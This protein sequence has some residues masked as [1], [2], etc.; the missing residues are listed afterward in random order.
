MGDIRQQLRDL[1]KELNTELEEW[2]KIPKPKANVVLKMK[3]R[4]R[5]VLAIQKILLDNP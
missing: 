1:L 2:E 4:R 3:E 5:M